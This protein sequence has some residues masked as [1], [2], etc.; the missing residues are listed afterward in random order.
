MT[1]LLRPAPKNMKTLENEKYS[2]AVELHHISEQLEELITL[3]KDSAARTEEIQSEEP[4]PNDN[5]VMTVK[6]AAKLMRI[7]LP[8]MYE[9]AKSGRVHAINIGRRVLISRSSLMALLREG[10]DNV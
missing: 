8:M 1:D 4:S 7:S 6:E 5:E 10:D 2:S 9:F 3:L